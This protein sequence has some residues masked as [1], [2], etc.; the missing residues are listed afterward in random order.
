MHAPDLRSGILTLS[1]QHGLDAQRQ[2]ELLALAGL[3]GEPPPS[4][5]RWPLALGGLAALLLGLGVVMW[6]AANWSVWSRGTHFV[7]LQ[8]L[9]VLALVGAWQ[10]PR[11]R[12][13]FGGAAWLLQGALLAYFGQTYQTGADPW[14]LFAWWALLTLPLALALRHDAVWVPWGLVVALALLL[15]AVTHSGHRWAMG[16]DNL[17]VQMICVA[18]LAA[19]VL[20]LGEPLRPWTG[21]GPWAP[22]S[23][24]VWVCCASLGWGLEALFDSQVRTQF[25]LS[26][27]TLMLL[28]AAHWR[29]GDLVRLAAFALALNVWAVAGVARALFRGMDREPIAALLLM[30]L[31]AAGLLPGTVSLLMRKAKETA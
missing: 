10:V 29:T 11:A 28:L 2:R 3:A 4:L 16:A 12:V 30:G 13:A 23:A 31:F 20:A 26:G 15:W 25:W 17:R 19:L 6:V 18:L 24:A 22:R 21:S 8:S 9:W 27:G 1:Q 14:Q 7:I 5:A